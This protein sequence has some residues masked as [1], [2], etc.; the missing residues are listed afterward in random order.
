[1]HFSETSGQSHVDYEKIN[2]TFV[3]I[4]AAENDLPTQFT[5]LSIPTILFFPAVKSQ[6][7]KTAFTDRS[8][9]RV[10]PADKQLTVTNLLNFIIVNL[11]HSS[12][13][14]LA[15]NFCDDKCIENSKAVIQQQIDDENSDAMKDDL[16]DDKSHRKLFRLNYLS[17][18][19]SKR[20]QSHSH[21][22][23]KAKYWT[24]DNLNKDEL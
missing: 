15:L 17:T 23:T 18:I 3:T 20:Q 9:T 24:I 11:P 10:F 13:T 21:G 4:D 6:N 8:D 7:N 12:R 14:Q 22:S 5:A 19:L 2:I 1:M 16:I